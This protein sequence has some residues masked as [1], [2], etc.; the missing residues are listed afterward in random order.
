MAC[1]EPGDLLVVHFG[2]LHNSVPGLASGLTA[3]GGGGS[4][5]GGPLG[6][7]SGYRVLQNGDTTAVLG[8]FSSSANA[9]DRNWKAAIYRGQHATPFGKL[10]GTGGTT[11]TT[12]YPAL[13]SPLNGGS[14]SWVIG[15]AHGN[16]TPT[17]LGTGPGAMVHRG[18]DTTTLGPRWGWY[19]TNAAVSSWASTTRN[20]GLNNWQ[21]NTWELRAAASGSLVF[22]DIY[23]ANASN[24]PTIPAQ[25]VHGNDYACWF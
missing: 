21:S 24:Q 13:T 15:I 25:C 20:H 3:I 17:G 6:N 18:S 10:N 14:T 9:N 12:T 19:D 7:R 4:Q 11:T 2:H 22:V 8:T 16:G 23:G 5:A 1:W